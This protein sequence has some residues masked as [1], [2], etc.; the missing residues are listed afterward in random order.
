MVGKASCGLPAGPCPPAGPGGVPGGCRTGLCRRSTRHM[1]GTSPAAPADRCV[2]ADP[3]AAAPPSSPAPTAGPPQR[4]TARSH[5]ARRPSCRGRD[6]RRRR[7]S[8]RA[9]LR[10]PATVSSPGRSASPEPFRRTPRGRQ[11]TCASTGTRTGGRGGSVPH[12][13]EGAAGDHSPVL[14]REAELRRRALE[15]L[16]GWRRA[17]PAPLERDVG[18]AREEQRVRSAAA[19]EGGGSEP[20][21]RGGRPSRPRGAPCLLVRQSPRPASGAATRTPLPP[22]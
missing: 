20:A 13:R 8:W 17:A 1:V 12:K 16:K 10:R 15:G 4:R 7:C 6:H 18:S 5:A 14:R 21:H 11:R 2:H 22:S 3:P 19:A 9:S